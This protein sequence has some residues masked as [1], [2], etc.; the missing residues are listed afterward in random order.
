MSKV[1]ECIHCG[2]APPVG[3]SL[4]VILIKHL[5]T[6]HTVFAQDRV[7]E[8][9]RV[10]FH[11]QLSFIINDLL[12]LP[13]TV[14]QRRR[15]LLRWCDEKNV[16]LPFIPLL[17]TCEYSTKIDIH[18][19]IRDVVEQLVERLSFDLYS[20]MSSFH[21]GIWSCLEDQ[22]GHGLTNMRE[23]HNRYRDNGDGKERTKPLISFLPI[24]PLL[25]HWHIPFHGG[26]LT[27]NPPLTHHVLN[28]RIE[29][30][31][32]SEGLLEA[33]WLASLGASPHTI[34]HH[35]I[36][37]PNTPGNEKV[38]TE[39]ELKAETKWRHSLEKGT[40]CDARDATTR[41]YHATVVDTSTA[42]AH[43]AALFTG[44]P[45]TPHQDTNH[46][47]VLVRYYGWS[48]RWDEWIDSMSPRLLPRNSHVLRYTLYPFTLPGIVLNDKGERR[49]EISSS[50]SSPYQRALGFPPTK[51]PRQRQEMAAAMERG[52]QQW[53]VH[54]QQWIN[55]VSDTCQ[56]MTVPV[57]LIV[58][59]YHSSLIFTS[60]EATTIK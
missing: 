47:I 2:Y 44:H 42:V 53:L 4:I 60:S 57:V 38:I 40:L 49:Y 33:E 55:I 39:E 23:H 51:P 56:N 54:R 15:T 30:N 14:S 7:V 10:K 21:P 22:G 59:D 24:V 8:D 18:S 41:W 32:H 52:H 50:L 37:L 58:L 29:Q 26:V 36:V 5:Q 25:L 16:P 43:P 13:L 12:S 28:V 17:G 1:L 6:I 45:D 46:K 19:F 35:H 3:G 34:D 27:A 11:H 31:H 20:M 48:E 9:D